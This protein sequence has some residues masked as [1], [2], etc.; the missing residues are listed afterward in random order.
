[1]TISS[2]RET[3]F[4]AAERGAT[5]VTANRHAAR[6]L[7]A[8]FDRMQSERGL[9]A[10]HSPDFISWPAL[11]SRL[12]NRLVMESAQP[13]PAVLSP[14]QE[15]RLWEKIVGSHAAALLA[16]DAWCLVHDYAID[17]NS[18]SVRKMFQQDE[19]EAF[20][21]WA[22]EFGRSCRE[23][24]VRS[25]A[26]LPAHLVHD[27]S[28]TE[29]PSEL[30]TLGFDSFTPTQRGLL[31]ALSGR[32]TK[33]TDVASPVEINATVVACHSP[34]EELDAV[35]R[36]A[37]E[38]LQRDSTASLGI[39]VPKLSE[40]RAALERSLVASLQ[41][42]SVLPENDASPLVHFS[43]GQ[44]LAQ[45]PA[46][47]TALLLLRWCCSP[48]KLDEISLL[49]RSPFLKGASA[50]QWSRALLDVE[51]HR[52]ASPRLSAEEVWRKAT[53]RDPVAHSSPIFG[54]ALWKVEKI[55]T[56]PAMPSAWRKEFSGVLKR[57]G[58]PGECQMDS[59]AFQLQE[60]EDLLQEYALLDEIVGTLGL[61]A[62]VTLLEQLAQ[63]R[64][65]EPADL[66]APVQVMGAR[67]AAGCE[68]DAVWTANLDAESWPQLGRP[69]PFLP[70]AL[71]REKQMPHASDTLDIAF[72][73][74]TLRRLAASAPE[75]I[76]SHADHNAERE[77]RP[78]FALAGYRRSSLQQILPET[79]AS[80]FDLLPYAARKDFPAPA[81][82]LTGSSAAGGRTVL[83]LQAACPFRAFAEIR[84]HARGVDA[85]D[86][87]PD[88]SERG[89]LLHSVMKALW[90]KMRTWRTLNAL[91]DD[92]LTASIQEA[93][94][95]GLRE[96]A[97]SFRGQLGEQ[98]R[99]VERGRLLPLVLVWLAEERRRMPFEVIA[100]E[101]KRECEIGGLKVNVTRDRVD[102]LDDGR[103]IVLDYKTGEVKSNLWEGDRPDDPQLPIYAMIEGEA[104]LAGVAF[105]QLKAGQV[106][107]RGV[108]SENGLLP[109]KNITTLPAGGGKTSGL[110]AETERWRIVLSR[111]AEDFLAGEAGVDPK[112]GHKTCRFCAL[113]S[114]CRIAERRAVP[115]DAEAG[116]E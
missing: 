73:E 69:N 115:F 63:E 35:A 3:L 82:P 40:Q 72:G 50:E 61:P 10:W 46:I 100:L 111:L 112:S 11:V 45:Q 95:A 85:P 102:Q 90:E 42:G 59:T 23:L 80:W 97:S 43:L 37:R 27:T 31:Q 83:K 34:Q 113:P 54:K 24:E 68:F 17:L 18:R 88:A 94:D 14:A 77:L 107:F 2:T 65:F 56:L 48:L 29:L 105:A 15:T 98:F 53:P 91:A 30:L 101:E 41:P 1:M 116:D 21:K 52:G 58:W 74:R 104:P 12:W 67:E 89:K 64:L 9:K 110:E 78:T 6:K 92:E 22:D 75:V 49:L 16:R 8:D 76:L 5:I 32:G 39:V 70:L 93:I 19:P 84:L 57:C 26:E 25:D 81:P 114:F 36:W 86:D 47:A 28:S 55:P 33:C 106:G 7:H 38:R 4:A 96:C 62:G 66:G 103:R 99:E 51:L 79:A 87:G 44:P 60:W 71:Q 108:Q 13:V 20:L 109:G